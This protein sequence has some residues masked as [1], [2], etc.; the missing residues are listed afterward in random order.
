MELHIFNGDCA[1][2][3]W[4]KANGSGPALVW[5]ENYLEGRI[6]G[7]DTGT[8]EFARIRA[9]ELHAMMP[10]LAED[11]LLASLNTMDRTL[12]GLAAG[13]TAYLWFDACMYDQM[14]LARILFLLADSPAA[15]DLICEDIAWGDHPELFAK[16]QSSGRRLDRDDRALYAAAWRA[17]ADGAEAIRALLPEPG[18]ARF[19]FLA[20]ALTRRLEDFLGADGLG[21]SER[22]L[23]AVIDAGNRTGSEIFRAFNKLE[24][25]PFMGDT[26]CWRL[27]DKLA[28]K[29]R[30]VID[31]IG[32]QNTY[33]LK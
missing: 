12:A 32:K 17:F 29:G 5:R 16:L 7:P 23:L 9:E 26:T 25:H 13:D 21:R 30:L 15:L 1:F 27:L 4:R 19:P 8:A 10:E 2:D 6:P 14:M 3:A 33:S 24:E 20:K 22:Q 28:A 11:R 18:I 31:H